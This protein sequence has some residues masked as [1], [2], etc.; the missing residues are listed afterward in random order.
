MWLKG[1]PLKGTPA[2]VLHS[3]L[4][5]G[6]LSALYGL[7]HIFETGE[8]NLKRW[9]NPGTDLGTSVVFCFR[10]ICRNYENKLGHKLLEFPEFPLYLPVL[11][12]EVAAGSKQLDG[13]RCWE[14]KRMVWTG[15]DKIRCFQ[16]M[17]WDDWIHPKKV[18]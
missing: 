3:W 15:L 1:D 4:A 13:S 18:Q 12:P 6:P 9:R 7:Q 14:N 17:P 10:N 8:M 5:E 2:E 11:R 16:K